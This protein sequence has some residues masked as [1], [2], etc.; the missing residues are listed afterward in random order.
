MQT[1]SAQHASHPQRVQKLPK[2]AAAEGLLPPAE[3]FADALS[4]SFRLSAQLR[5]TA[6]CF[7]A[8]VFTAKGPF[9]AHQ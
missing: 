6:D 8:Q 1:K 4:K 9:V 7:T 5:L 3:D 2:P